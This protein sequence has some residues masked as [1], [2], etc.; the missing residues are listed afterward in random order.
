MA[1]VLDGIRVFELSQIV[2]APYCGVH[3]AD[4]GAD[5]VKVEPPG[6]EGLRVLGAVVPGESKTFHTLNRGKRSLVLDLK[7]PEAQALLHRVIE[8]FDVF[9]INARPGVAA[10]LGA[11]YDTLSALRPDLVYM[12]NTGYGTR[13]PSAGRSGSDIVA[14]AYSGLMAGE[15]KV[16]AFG[17]PKSIAS[18]AVAD[19]ATGLAAAMA[20]CGALYRRAVSGRGECIQTSLL[21]TA[22]SV[23]GGRVAQMPAHDRVVVDPL[24]RRLDEMRASGATYGELVAVR[25]AANTGSNR[26]VRLYYNGYQVQDGAVIL[27]ALTPANRDQMR[28][29]LGITDDPT[30]DPAFDPF[31]PANEPLFEELEARIRQLMLGAPMAE[32]MERFDRE[33]APVA[34][35][36]FPETMAADPQ[37]EAM[38]Y[39]QSLEHEVTG[40]EVMVGPVATMRHHPMGSPRPS[41]PLGR[42]TDE[43]LGELGVAPAEIAALRTAGAIG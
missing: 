25:D 21:Q 10:R 24:L 43:V 19:Y 40:P 37:V 22:L 26:A 34:Q 42:H 31:D 32:W 17:A 15:G 13:G 11:D 18:T 20:I 8:Q 23:Q 2:A 16:D 30:A 14:Q 5:V 38:G 41:P 6:G 39:M 1:G 9:V 4:M 36:N 27:G 12:E 29:A 7:R 33:G 35:V 28:R 3:L